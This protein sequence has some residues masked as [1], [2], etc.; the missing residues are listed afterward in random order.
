MEI[1]KGVIRRGPL[2]DNTLRDLHNFSDDTQP[3]SI[4]VKHLLQDQLSWNIRR[5]NLTTSDSA[6]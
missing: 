4:T 3:R 5:S 6:T 2:A 1:E